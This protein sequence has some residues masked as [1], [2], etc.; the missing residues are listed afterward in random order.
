[1]KIKHFILIIALIFAAFLISGLIQRL[2]PKTIS[3]DK[4]S[5]FQ[6]EIVSFSIKAKINLCIDHL[7]YSIRNEN[8]KFVNLKHSCSGFIGSSIDCYCKNRTIDCVPV[9]PGCSDVI[10]CRKEKVDALFSWNQMEYIKVVEECEGVIIQREE[11]Q[12]VEC[13]KYK[14]IVG[15][16]EKSFSIF[17]K[18]TEAKP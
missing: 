14:I 15:D 1:M 13:G 16:Y 7:P 4:G 10:V 12:Q 9:G 8:G 18:V 2:V 11:P 17:P 3:L 5:F 6:G